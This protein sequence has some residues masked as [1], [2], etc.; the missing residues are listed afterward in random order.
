MAFVL[1]FKTD[2]AAFDE[3]EAE[4]ARILRAIADKLENGRVAGKCQDVNGNSVGLWSLNGAK[5]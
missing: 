2:N 1:R 3:P 4:C 5:N